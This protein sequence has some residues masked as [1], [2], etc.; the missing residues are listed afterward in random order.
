MYKKLKIGFAFNFANSGPSNFL[1]KLMFSLKLKNIA[2]V[3]FYINPFTNVNVYSNKIRNPWKKPFLYRV[4]GVGFDSDKSPAQLNDINSELKKGIYNSI[5]VIYQSNFSKKLAESI[6]KIKSH[7]SKIIIN[8]TDL[9][10]FNPEGDN[11]RDSFNIPKDALVFISSAKWRP[12]KRL[13]DMVNI[14]KEFKNLYK[15]ET[16]F[17]VLGNEHK[18]N[19]DNIIYV[20]LQPNEHLPKYLRTADIYLFLGWLDPCPNSVVEAIA[21]GLPTI[22]TNTGGTLEIVE[23]TSGGIVVQADKDF[24]FINVN[25]QK[26]PLPNYDLILKAMFEMSNNLDFY[27]KKINKK[28]IDINY[29]AKSYYEFLEYC[30]ENK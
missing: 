9:D 12:R 7:K 20:P 23:Q 24:K 10:T 2:I 27:K 11:L 3:S 26:P 19:S 18:K 15:K 8:G 14:F 6:L 16:Y 29:T 17:I 1:K 5:G 4:D 21:C 22:C 13:N 30:Y 28:S 25:L